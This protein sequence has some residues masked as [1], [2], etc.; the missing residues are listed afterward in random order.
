[1]AE[2]KG[3]AVAIAVAKAKLFDQKLQQGNQAR[4]RSNQLAHQVQMDQ[5]MVDGFGAVCGLASLKT[6]LASGDCLEQSCTAASWLA[7]LQ[8]V[9]RAHDGQGHFAIGCWE[10]AGNAQDA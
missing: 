7:E 10:M 6:Q 9:P 5:P 1:M 3:Q 4:F 2:P 8:A